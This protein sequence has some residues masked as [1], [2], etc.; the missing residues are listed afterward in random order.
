MYMIIDPGDVCILNYLLICFRN[1]VSIA[2]RLFQA[3]S[4]FV[5]SSARIK[6]H[7]A[8]EQRA[9]TYSEWGECEEMKK[10]TPFCLEELRVRQ[11][12]E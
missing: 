12:P 5:I 6:I 7:S 9:L 2:D 4:P 8:P 1:R 11:K 3:Y 10:G